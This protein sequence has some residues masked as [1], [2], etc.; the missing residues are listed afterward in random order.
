MYLD[1][2]YIFFFK[3]HT[4]SIIVCTGH[5]TAGGGDAYIN[6]ETHLHILTKFKST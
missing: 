3:C 6:T 4:S 1:H 5:F 2:I